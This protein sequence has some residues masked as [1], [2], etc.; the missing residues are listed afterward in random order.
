MQRSVFS[1]ISNTSNEKI[2]LV[3]LTQLKQIIAHQKLVAFELV[4]PVTSTRPSGAQALILQVINTL[5]GRGSG[6][7]RLQT[8]SHFI[9]AKWHLIVI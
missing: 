2:P 1:S 3:T 5:H 7:A 8:L 6:H 9:F 4:R